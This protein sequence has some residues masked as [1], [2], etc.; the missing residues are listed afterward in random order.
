MALFLY[1]LLN[2]GFFFLCHPS[3]A[4]GAYQE[5]LELNISFYNIDNSVNLEDCD[6]FISPLDRKSEK[7]PII[8]RPA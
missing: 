3:A 1:T 7:D 4:S 2:I 5:L 8:K 6:Q